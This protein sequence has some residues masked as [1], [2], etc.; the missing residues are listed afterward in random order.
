MGRILLDGNPFVSTNL[1]PTPASMEGLLETVA[2]HFS[3]RELKAAYHVLW[4]TWNLAH[5]TVEEEGTRY[6]ES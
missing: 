5:K 3:G 1:A 6:Q 4:M 2:L